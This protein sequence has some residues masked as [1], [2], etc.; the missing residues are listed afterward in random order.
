MSFP[1]YLKGR[2][3]EDYR[4]L[5]LQKLQEVKA[6]VENLD[7]FLDSSLSDL[8]TNLRNSL[9]RQVSQIRENLENE[10]NQARDLISDNLKSARSSREALWNDSNPDSYQPQ[11]D[12]L[13]SDI[14]LNVPAPAK[15]ENVDLKSLAE[16]AGRL[17]EVGTQSEVLNVVLNFVS[18]WVDRAVLFVVKGEQ[19]SGWAAIGLGLGYQSSPPVEN[20]LIA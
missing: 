11:V 9:D 15:S 7:G 13:I 12:S 3:S 5:I 17:D 14:V 4:I 16:L 10:L 18:G 1:E 6:Q 19:A 2:I 8:S 20:R